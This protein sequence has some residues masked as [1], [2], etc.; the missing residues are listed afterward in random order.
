MSLSELS[1]AELFELANQRKKNEEL[2]KT[3]HIREERSQLKADKASL[4]AEHKKALSA[5]DRQINNLQK[6]LGQPGNSSGESKR[7]MSTSVLDFIGSQDQASVSDI[8]QY[9]SEQGLNAD[10]VG[11]QLAYLKRHG[12]VLIVSRGVY[13]LPE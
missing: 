11:Q 4:V 6:K 5:I 12:R 3:A 9:L 2:A 13:S 10:N 1:S 8:K 7:G